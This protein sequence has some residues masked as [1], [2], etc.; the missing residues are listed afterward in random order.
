MCLVQRDDRNEKGD[1]IL[2]L[3]LIKT[4][5]ISPSISNTIF[6]YLTGNKNH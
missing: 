3:L 5:T 2:I 6:A 1:V 4:K